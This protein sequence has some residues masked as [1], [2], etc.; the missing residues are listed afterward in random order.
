[1]PQISSNTL[2]TTDWNASDL[3]LSLLGAVVLVGA[4]FLLIGWLLR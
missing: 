2:P 4:D 3:L 1:M